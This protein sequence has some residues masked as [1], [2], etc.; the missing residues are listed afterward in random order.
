MGVH[1]AHVG[2][3]LQIRHACGVLR[4]N[5]GGQ[6]DIFHINAEIFHAD[7][8][9]LVARLGPDFTIH[10]RRPPAERARLSV[11]LAKFEAAERIAEHLA[12]GSSG[13]YRPLARA[14]APAHPEYALVVGRLQLRRRVQ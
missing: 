12:L 3:D 5:A 4:R 1:A 13:K 14:P 7:Q 10:I 2:F 11:E 6:V 9:F 8:H